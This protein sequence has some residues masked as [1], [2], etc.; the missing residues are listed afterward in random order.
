[1]DRLMID[2]V[3][4]LAQ[5]T[6]VVQHP[7]GAAMRRDRDVAGVDGKVMHR[8]ARHVEPERLP[9]GAVV[10]RHVDAELGARL[11]QPLAPG[12]GAHYIARNSVVTGKSVSGSGG[13]G[14][15]LI[16]KTKKSSKQEKN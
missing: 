4:P 2:I 14:G 3:G 11:E 12:I 5:R 9:V 7:E 13:I 15:S 10:E 6:D 1:M 8:H 16:L